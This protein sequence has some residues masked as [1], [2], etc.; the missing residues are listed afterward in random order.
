MMRG[1]VS[2]IGGIGILSLTALHTANAATGSAPKSCWADAKTGK[3]VIHASTRGGQKPTRVPCAQHIE[4][5]E[6]KLA[7]TAPGLWLSAALLT[8]APPVPATSWWASAEA[9]V[10]WAKSAPLPPTLTT[11]APGSPSATTGAGGELGV[12]GTIVLSPDNL[13]YDPFAG[14]RFT[15]GRWLDPVQSLGIEV[16]GLFLASRSAGFSDA[17]GGTPP[18]RIPFTNV[19]PGAG[20]PLGSSSFVIADPGFAAGSQ[21]I[22]SSLQFWGVEGNVLFHA[23]NTGPFKV[24]LLSGIRY[25]DLRENLSIVSN[26]TPLPSSGFNGSFAATDGFATRNQFIGAQVGGKAQAQYGQFDGLL[27]AK[28]A[29]G[30]NYQTVG[31][32]GSSLVSGFG[33]FPAVPVTVPGGIFAQSTNIGQQTRNQ[34]AAVP[35]VQ[36]QVGYKLPYG[37]RAFVGYD[38]LYMSNVVRPGNQIDTTLNFT[39][40]QGVNPGGTLTGAARP[41]PQFNG[42][43]FWVQGINF[44]AGVSF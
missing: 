28:V 22:D 8:K 35:E 9:L 1:L 33:V 11:F 18:L 24:S 30:D 7:P 29:L 38:F 43:S 40:S 17:S 12:P 37:I 13:N 5:A 26:E 15:L 14:G 42:S 36:V 21:S 34:F 6:Q 41:Q 4:S 3:P 32:S 10:W 31:V 2:L 23:L 27:L 39:G 44:G 19:P 20:F 25:L 16:D